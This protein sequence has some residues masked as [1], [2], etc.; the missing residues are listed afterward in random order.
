MELSASSRVDSVQE[1]TDNRRVS[2]SLKP[3]HLWSTGLRQSP[4]NFF[5]HLKTKLESIGFVSQTDID[6][7]LFISDKVICLSYVNDTCGLAR[8]RKYIDEAMNQ[9][10]EV[11]MA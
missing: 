9:L 6:P 5:N 7:C 8:N 11:G 10:R 2:T 3:L 1:V 4:R